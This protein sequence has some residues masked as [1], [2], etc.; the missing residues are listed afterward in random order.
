[1]TPKILC[2]GFAF[3]EGPRWH[4]GVLWVSDMHGDAVFKISLDGS[5][6]KVMDVPEQPSGLGWLPNG[7]ML[8]VSMLDKK[9]LR[10]KPDGKVSEHA[11]V[12]ALVPRRINDMIVD[13][14]GRAWVGNFGFLFDE[15]EPPAS[16]VLVRVD[17]DGSYHFAADNLMFPNGM[18]ITDN[19]KTLV[20]AE[21]FGRK[22]TAFDIDEDSILSNR[23]TWAEMP[24]SAVPDG[25]CLDAEGG[26]W[27]A[28]PTTGEA[29]R[30][31]EGGEVTN[32]VQTGRMA[33]AT[34]LG[35]EDGKT[36]FVLTSESTS[37]KECCDAASAR[38]EYVPVDVG[39]AV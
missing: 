4:D 2:D 26:I 30:F 37:R 21:T 23:R 27:V 14:L 7:D 31:V 8:I 1:M 5:Y 25:I 15:G 38:V 12:S 18:V 32:S 28:S 3:L 35:G 29:L 22:L 10:R 19:G 34:A 36:L 13:T 16:T 24:E 20:V 33:I 9:L 11:D 17:P 6:E 39:A